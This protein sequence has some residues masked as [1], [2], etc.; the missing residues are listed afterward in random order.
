MAYDIYPLLPLGTGGEIERLLREQLTDLQ[1]E[2]V[3]LR[4]SMTRVAAR[5]H[6]A[7]VENHGLRVALLEAELEC[8]ALRLA[9]GR[10]AMKPLPSRALSN[11]YSDQLRRLGGNGWGDA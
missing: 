1:R 2:A 11:A 10:P 4:A 5:E 3:L 9:L 8:A 7:L 6:S